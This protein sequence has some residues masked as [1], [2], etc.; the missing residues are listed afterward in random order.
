MRLV[1]LGWNKSELIIRVPEL[2][3]SIY[4]FTPI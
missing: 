1:K 4:S 3:P 2:R